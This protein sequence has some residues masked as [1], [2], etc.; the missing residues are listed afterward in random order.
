MLHPSRFSML[1]AMFLCALLSTGAQAQFEVYKTVDDLTNK[2]PQTYPGF[3][4]DSQ[5]GMKKDSKIELKNDATE[6]KVEIDCSAIWGFSYMGQL[7][8]IAK[9]G[10]YY[11]G[12]SAPENMPVELIQYRDGVFLWFNAPGL[13]SYFQKAAKRKASGKDAVSFYYKPT[14]YQGFLSSS[15]DGN[16]MVLLGGKFFGIPKWVGDAEEDFRRDN[17]ELQWLTDCAKNLWWKQYGEHY[18]YNVVK[19]CIEDH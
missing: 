3:D 19:G 13:L 9:H 6:E 18:D 2:T 17:P 15:V 5:K 14:T 12:N 10:K 1:A 4:F 11:D 16:L 7:F 8:R